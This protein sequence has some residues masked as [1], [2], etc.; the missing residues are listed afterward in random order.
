MPEICRFYGIIIKMYF[1]DHPPPHFHVSYGE[2]EE[3]IEIETG[4]VLQGFLPKTAAYL[5]ESWREQHVNDLEKSWTSAQKP[6]VL[7]KIAPLK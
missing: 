5:V 3:L 6:E 7:K 1:N 2:H 4:E